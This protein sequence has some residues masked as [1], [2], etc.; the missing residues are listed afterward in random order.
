MAVLFKAPPPNQKAGES[1]TVRAK[2]FRHVQLSPG[3]QAYLWWSETHGGSGLAARAVVQQVRQVAGVC[4]AE[5]T[6]HD[7]VSKRFGKS[8]LAPFR[9]SEGSDPATSLARR[10]YRHAHDKVTSL[11]AA[12]EAFLDGFFRQADEQ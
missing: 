4:E 9:D 12:E 6:I 7:R 1:L 2:I 5:V 11:D 3:D 10:L 8:D